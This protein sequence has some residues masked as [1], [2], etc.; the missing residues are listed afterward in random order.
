MKPFVPHI[1]K[2]P[3]STVSTTGTSVQVLMQKDREPHWCIDITYSGSKGKGSD[4]GFSTNHLTDVLD[5]LRD[6]S[7]SDREKHLFLTELA[8][9]RLLSDILVPVE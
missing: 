4:W 1:V 2:D 5:C 8:A 3:E 7:R 9:E 6:I